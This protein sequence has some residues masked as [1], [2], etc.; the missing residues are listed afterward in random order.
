MAFI[1]IEGRKLKMRFLWVYIV[2]SFV[3]A[4]AFVFP[5]FLAMRERKLGQ[6]ELAAGKA[7]D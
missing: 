1:V 5:L 4:F 2:A 3:T 7:Q 6:I